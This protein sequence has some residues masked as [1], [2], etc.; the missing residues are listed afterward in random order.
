VTAIGTQP[1]EQPWSSSPV[2]VAVAL[3]TDAQGG[4]ST[5]E[6]SRRLEQG[7]NV[8]P[9]SAPRSLLSLVLDQLHETLIVVLLLAAVATVIVGDLGDALIIA[10]VV[11]LNTTLGVV[12]ERRAQRA[13][14]ALA[15]LAPSS[16]RVVRSGRSTMVPAE[17]VVVGDVL[18]LQAGDQVPADGRLVQAQGLEVVESALT[19]E[20]LPVAK[21]LDACPPDSPVADRTCML[22][23]GTN[24]TRGRARAVVTT[25]GRQ[26][27]VGRLAHLLVTTVSPPT[28]LQVR[29]ARFGRQV[30]AATV[31]LCVVV[32]AL[33]L[34]RGEPLGT[35]VLAAVSLAV[36]AVPE[37]LPA[38][39]V[40]SLAM[41][42]QRMAARA[43]VVRTLPAVEALGS[44]TVIASDKTGTLTEGRMVVPS[45]W[46]PTGEVAVD[47]LGYGP[48]GEL[49]GSEQAVLAGASLI[50][51]VALCN[52]A[53]LLEVE[54]GWEVA[55]DPMEGALLSLASKAGWPPEQL[56]AQWPRVAEYGFDHD[57]ARMT[58]VH[59]SATG[60]V[61]VCCKGAPEVVLDL[62]GHG[63]AVTAARRE[64]DRMTT[65]GLRVLAVAEAELP[66][67]PQS[68]QEAWSGCT[69][70][71]GPPRLLRSR[72]AGAPACT[73]S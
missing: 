41:A 52:D 45:F 44:V 36:A 56:R 73:P 10:L 12:Q 62:V 54:A 38:V 25:T 29:L 35:M 19:G 2:Q 21:T 37:S 69:T 34:L 60:T 63:A 59:G 7:R 8:L 71:P 58:T 15:T 14:A 31:A 27:Q 39:V 18:E 43:A 49:H 5:Q 16:A 3:Q 65:A 22:H 33:G 30:A 4:L 24:V 20:S 70:P 11:T 13:I 72:P 48:S 40:L 26:T 6:A 50:R 47:G 42:A 68:Q 28:P 66:A 51:A 17:E 67:Q 46:T 55:G 64:V 32:L 23:G 61:L 1:L 53:E 9:R 57:R